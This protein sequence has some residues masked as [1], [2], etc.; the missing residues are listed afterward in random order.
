MTESWI[1]NLIHY[2]ASNVLFKKIVYSLFEFCLYNDSNNLTK[3]RRFQSHSAWQWEVFC[4]L[5]THILLH[6]CCS[7]KFTWWAAKGYLIIT[8]KNHSPGRMW[9]LQNSAQMLLVLMSE[10]FWCWL[11]RLHVYLPFLLTSTN[12]TLLLSRN[13]RY[14][15][16]K[17]NL[18]RSTS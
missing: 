12:Y 1:I 15:D 6:W 18:L 2:N 10:G 14:P 9:N 4:F 3:I 16:S 13:D 11:M 17:V 8:V 5:P 7:V